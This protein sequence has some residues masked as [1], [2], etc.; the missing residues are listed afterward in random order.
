MRLPLRSLELVQF[1]C[2][3]VQMES[4]NIVCLSDGD[5]L[6]LTLKKLQQ[7]HIRMLAFFELPCSDQ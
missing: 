7:L 5:R 6:P 2:G 4:Q 1:R 3:A